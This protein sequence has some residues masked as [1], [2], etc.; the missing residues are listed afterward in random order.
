M[1]FNNISHRF[2]GN[3]KEPQYNAN[4]LQ[5]LAYATRVGQSLRHTYAETPL[6]FGSRHIAVKQDLMK[7]AGRFHLAV[8][9]A[10]L[11]RN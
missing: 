10:I 5:I 4:C 6:R 2:L 7:T 11:Q 9:D 8:L 1:H 3:P